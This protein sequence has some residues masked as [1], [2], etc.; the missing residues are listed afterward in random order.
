MKSGH[1]P[2]WHIH[3]SWTI[4]CESNLPGLTAEPIATDLVFTSNPFSQ[5]GW[6]PKGVVKQ[7]VLNLGLESTVN[8]CFNPLATVNYCFNPFAT[9]N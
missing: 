4:I 9:V 2:A 3:S 8:Y 1:L 5:T 6:S 7:H